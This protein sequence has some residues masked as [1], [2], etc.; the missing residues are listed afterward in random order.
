MVPFLE[1]EFNGWDLPQIERKVFINY[2][3]RSTVCQ[4][5]MPD[6]VEFLVL[7]VASEQIS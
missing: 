6:E 4:W 1:A 2:Y 5:Y 7:T 3:L